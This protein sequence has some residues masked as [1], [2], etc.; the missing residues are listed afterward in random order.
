VTLDSVQIGAIRV[1]NVTAAVL[2]GNHPMEILLG[3]TFLDRV[4]MRE[5]KGVLMLISKF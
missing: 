3:M 1:H 5:E 2:P 4:V